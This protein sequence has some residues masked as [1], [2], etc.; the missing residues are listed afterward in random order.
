MFFDSFCED[1]DCSEYT[2]QLKLKRRIIGL[3]A[4]HFVEQ[5]GRVNMFDHRVFGDK[6]GND[7]SSE[8]FI[9]STTR[10]DKPRQCICM[11]H[12][13]KIGDGTLELGQYSTYKKRMRKIKKADKYSKRA[14][15]VMFDKVK[16][17]FCW[18]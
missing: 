12:Q 10:S 4:E 1:G 11:I 3:K 15:G 9:E 13:S 2:D 16:P 17:T 6:E 14:M 7:C 8:T 5:N 18:K